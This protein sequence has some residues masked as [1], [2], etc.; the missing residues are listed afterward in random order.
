MKNRF[1]KLG[2]ISLALVLVLGLCGVGFARWSDT[3][4]IEGTVTAG[5]WDNGGT[6]GFWKNWDKHNTY[7]QDD[8]ESWLGTIDG[9]SLWLVSDRDGNGKINIDDME[10]ILSQKC[11]K[12]MKCK[13]LKQYLATRLN[14]ESGLLSAGA[15]HNFATLDLHDY[16]G[17]G[18]SGTLSDIIAA[19]ESKY[20][21]DPDDPEAVWPAPDEYEI[22]KNVCDYLNN[23]GGIYPH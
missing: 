19:M 2:F 8:I 21:E 5:T 14:V 9:N 20:P 1:G 4:A 23:T 12:D 22:M 13:F 16:L 17:L 6:I 18:G 7:T 11:K 15:T 10:D 3:V